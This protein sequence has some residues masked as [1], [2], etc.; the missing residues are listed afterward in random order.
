MV[1]DVIGTTTGDKKGLST[2]VLAPGGR[3]TLR[4][5]NVVKALGRLIIGCG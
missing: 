5:V 4:V 3:R 1:K 2:T